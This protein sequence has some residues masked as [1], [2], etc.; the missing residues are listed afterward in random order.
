MFH[1]LVTAGS[2]GDIF[3]FVN[4]LASNTKATALIVGGA[5][6]VIVFV[7]GAYKAKGAIAGLIM[8]F[9]CAVLA[10]WMLTTVNKGGMN[11]KIENTVNNGMPAVE[12]HL[13]PAPGPSSSGLD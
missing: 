7:V 10:G 2:G 1:T 5:I 9:C 8:A 12:H 6:I 13:Q 11:D 4:N 3:S